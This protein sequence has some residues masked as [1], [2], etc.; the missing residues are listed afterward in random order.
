MLRA[1]SGRPWVLRPL[2]RNHVGERGQ[3]SPAPWPPAFLTA[4]GQLQALCVACLPAGASGAAVHRALMG[5]VGLVFLPWL[6][7]R[8]RCL[9]PR[10]AL[11]SCR[12]HRSL[13]LPG[14]HQSRFRGPG[15]L[16]GPG[17]EGRQVFSWEDRYH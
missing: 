8:P 10:R 2:E 7:T 14:S 5:H 3:A 4:R 15:G 12:C 11:P 17:G 6:V 1:P 9:G 16:P 13:K